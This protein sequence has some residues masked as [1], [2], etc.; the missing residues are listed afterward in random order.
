MKLK[1]LII[2]L[3]IMLIVPIVYSIVDCKGVVNKGDLPCLII[4]SWQ[5]SCATETITIYNEIPSLLR[6][7]TL[8]NYTGTGRCNITFGV[9]SNETEIGSYLLNWSS[10]DSSKIIVEEDNNM[11]IALVI[12]ITFIVALF[13]FL[14]FAVKEDKPFLANFFFLGI[15]I[16]TTVLSNLLWKIT[17]INS[18]PYEPIMLIVY[19]I[20]L[21]ITFLMI[22]IVLVL[23]TVDA[24]QMRKWKG[25]PVD[26]YRDNLGKDERDKT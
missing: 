15:F 2:I 17:N 14:T 7:A 25:N 19:R 21:I 18:A 23:M 5:F 12:G 8:D 26:T 22:L 24:V 3:M 9:N 11:L 4:S 13:I 10:G 1:C 16:F 20:F 6:T